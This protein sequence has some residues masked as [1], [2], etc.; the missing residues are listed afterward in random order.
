M[1]TEEGCHQ[2]DLHL[3]AIDDSGTCTVFAADGCSTIFSADD[4]GVPLGV[5]T[6]EVKGVQLTA[7]SHTPGFEPHKARLGGGTHWC[8]VEQDKQPQF[9]V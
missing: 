5:S 4:C 7:T 9:M 2:N 3:T 6:G 8:A 1:S